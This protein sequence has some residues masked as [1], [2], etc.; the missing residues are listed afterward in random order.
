MLP[1][2]AAGDLKTSRFLLSLQDRHASGIVYFDQ[3]TSA[4]AGAAAAAAVIEVEVKVEAFYESEEALRAETRTI[5][6]LRPSRGQYGIGVFVSGLRVVLPHAS[7]RLTC[8]IPWR[9]LQA[10]VPGHDDI[11]LT[12]S[13]PCGYPG[14]VL[15]KLTSHS[16]N[17][18]HLHMPM[19]LATI[20]HGRCR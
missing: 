17:V 3:C 15:L 1:G 19:H 9:V 4:S 11:T 8:R 7:L 6:A 14:L 16:P 12:V 13:S 10:A 2:A 20:C 5:C 18:T